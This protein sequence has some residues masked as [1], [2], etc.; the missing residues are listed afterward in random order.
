MEE[1][2]EFFKSPESVIKRTKKEKS[3]S[4]TV[5]YQFLVSALFAIS[6]YIAAYKM[7][8]P[9]KFVST[10]A[11]AQMIISPALLAVV[12]F[13]TG[14]LGFFFAGFVTE[15]V[16]NTLG[17]KG[18]YFEGLTTGVYSMVPPSFGTLAAV[19]LATIPGGAILGMIVATITIALGYAIFYRALKELFNTDMVTALIG[20]SVITGS[21]ILGIYSGIFLGAGMA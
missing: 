18:R 3:M 12:C 19:L 7:Q 13:F 20:T 11:L 21:L 16:M 2:G 9:S 17:G 1:I 14:F 8:I 6:T 5:A 4:K 10:Q 15:I